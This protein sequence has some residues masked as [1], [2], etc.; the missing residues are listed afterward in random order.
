MSKIKYKR[1]P[2]EVKNNLWKVSDATGWKS[3]VA[4]RDNVEQLKHVIQKVA[5]VVEEPMVSVSL[6]EPLL[7]D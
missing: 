1:I 4:V 6:L 3:I 2:V 5:M 7:R